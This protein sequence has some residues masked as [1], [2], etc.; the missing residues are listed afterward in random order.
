MKKNLDR[1]L[2]LGQIALSFHVASAAVVRRVLER[3]GVAHTIVEAPHEKI[4]EM[5]GNGEIDMVVSAWLPGSHGAFI[6]LYEDELMKLGVLYEPYTI[7][8]VPDYVPEGELATVEDLRRPGVAAKMIK[9]IQGIG[10]GAGISRFSR[11]II[12]R[13]GLSDAGYEFRN[14]TLD[15][16]VGAYERAVAQR[17]WVVIPFWYPQFLHNAYKIRALSEPHGLL[18][19]KDQATLTVRKEAVDLLPEKTLATLRRMTLGNEAVAELDFMIS[20][21]KLEPLEAARQWMARNAHMVS[22]W[23]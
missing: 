22:S 21:N 23:G 16:C 4:Y 2:V 19:G 20:R 11:E 10:P 18:R 14:G 17:Q 13:Y 9:L 8:G 7:W 3:D 15:E 1:P 12:A 6:Q 5:L